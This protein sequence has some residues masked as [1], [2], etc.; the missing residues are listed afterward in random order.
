MSPGQDHSRPRGLR[1]C[2]RPSRRRAPD[3]CA[4]DRRKLPRRRLWR[5]AP[6]Q[7]RPP[8]AAPDRALSQAYARPPAPPIREPPAIGP[9]NSCPPSLPPAFL[10][11]NWRGLVLP[12][13]AGLSGLGSCSDFVMRECI[14]LLREIF[15]QAEQ[16]R[17]TF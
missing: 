2:D 5:G 8:P 4:P 16:A 13:W 12:D 9:A 17:A 14:G 15:G 10:A 3:T 11:A 7:G 6:D 1:S